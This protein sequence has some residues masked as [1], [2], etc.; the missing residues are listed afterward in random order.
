MPNKIQ[1]ELE[2]VV[3]KLGFKNLEQAIRE[4]SGMVH[5]MRRGLA[6]KYPSET[7]DAAAGGEGGRGGR[8]AAMGGRVSS[9]S[10]LAGVGGRVGSA[11]TQYG[12]MLGY[13]AAQMAV[14]AF[15]K[16]LN[17]GLKALEALGHV[18]NRLMEAAGQGAKLYEQSRALGV[19]TRGTAGFLSALGA[20]GIDERM[21]MRLAAYGEF[22]RR[23]QGGLGTRDL[24]GM[25]VSAGRS[26]GMGPQEIQQLVNMSHELNA[27]GRLLA[28]SVRQTAGAARENFEITAS[29]R[30]FK[31]D[32]DAFWQ[33]ISAK[34]GPAIRL[35]INIGDEFVRVINRAL[36]GIDGLSDSL[37]AVIANLARQLAT[38]II[39][40]G[41]GLTQI[42]AYL[43]GL[44]GGRSG[45]G[46]GGFMGGA[47]HAIGGFMGGAVHAIAGIGGALLGRGA[48]RIIA[49]IGNAMLGG[50]AMAGIGGAMAGIGNPLMA[51]GMAL[52]EATFAAVHRAGITEGAGDPSRIGGFARQTS[53]TSLERM[54]LVIGGGHDRT[55]QHLQNIDRNTAQTVAVM[56]FIA[57]ALHGNPRLFTEG[58][59]AASNQP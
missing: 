18:L 36:E 20:V 58:D 29:W 16:A 40:V 10:A 2:L 50:G 35:V 14:A 37:T 26:A 59:R 43:Q 31:A 21:A 4:N 56:H 7:P 11:L 24:A 12:V 34:L 27:A 52:R 5:A 32:F 44:S 19:S 23:G 17:L 53:F 3:K 48:G 6:E 25:M 1:V 41:N 49:G 30:I 22:G 55:L 39:N 13:E 9:L 15:T 33:L 54:G 28:A 42:A 45:S 51:V 8:L 47:A 57:A 38:L 46:S